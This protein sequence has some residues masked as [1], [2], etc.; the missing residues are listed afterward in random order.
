MQ[1]ALGLDPLIND[2]E[3]IAT[4]AGL[5]I[6]ANGAYPA[7]WRRRVASAAAFYRSGSE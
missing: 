6:S 5:V 4:V 1:Q 2:D 3:D 7:H